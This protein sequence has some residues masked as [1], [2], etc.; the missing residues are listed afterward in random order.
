MTP[1]DAPGP[2][3]L[4]TTTHAKLRAAQGDVKTARRILR[5]ILAARPADEEAGAL[6]A[7][8]SRAADR[9]HSE[10]QD[11]ALPPP[12]AARGED[13]SARFREA[14]AGRPA[15]AAGLRRR[16]ED[17]LRRIEEVRGSGRAR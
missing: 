8:I 10:P 17:L 7:T 16:L 5:A 13:L 4:L 1:T 2:D 11:D 12:E 6:L 9:S 14:L 15:A 3:P